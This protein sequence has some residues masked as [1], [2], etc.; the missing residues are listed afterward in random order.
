MDQAAR[1]VAAMREYLSEAPAGAADLPRQE[2]VDAAYE[3]LRRQFDAAWGGFGGAPKFPSPANLFLL[4]ELAD[5]PQADEMLDA[6]LDQMA[7]GGIYDQLGGG[8]HRYA[9]DREWKIP[10]FE[11]MLYDNGLLLEAYAQAHLRRPTPQRERILRQTTAFLA[12]EMT[13][14]EGGFWSAIDAE[15]EGH[16]G[17]FYVWT[18]DEL[19]GLLG[20]EDAAFLAPLF[21]F[22]GPPFFEG[23]HYVLHLPRPLEEQAALRQSSV[24]EIWSEVEPLRRKLFDARG[25]RERPRTDDKILAD[26]NG[27]A[28]A[29]L[30]WAGRALADEGVLEQARRAA[31]FVL[32]HHW[33]HSGAA[34]ALRHSWREGEAA[35]DGFLADYAYMVRGLLALH[36]ATGAE[37]W[38]AAARELTVE[39]VE[40][41]ETPEGG[42]FAAAAAPD[43]LLQSRDAYDD[44]LPNANGVA[45][46]N[47]LDLHAATGEERWRETAVRALVA[48][49]PA[50]ERQP[51][52]ARTL[53]LAG[54]RLRGRPG[55][56]PPSRKGPA[57]GVTSPET[58]VRHR[59]RVDEGEGWRPFV[60]ELE[61]EEGWH[62]HANPASE[63]PL[64][65]TRLEAVEG[66]LRN[67]TYPE[68]EPLEVGS[69]DAPLSVYQGVVCITGELRLEGERALCLTYQA[70]D[71]RRC[72]EVAERRIVVE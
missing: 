15:T 42:F 3:G 50:A 63:E 62:L 47:L 37:E 12:S 41:L 18:A 70:C 66:E 22:E 17:A 56:A 11:K 45:V 34:P 35:I 6:T 48:L 9:T 29:G 36:E 68:G 55:E 60:L 5:R 33:L 51:M 23:S 67:V 69:S 28:I 10:H 25:R 2:L 43:L 27:L 38:L 49:A 32:E 39:Q 30:A 65:P 4:L 7:R 19:R 59:L 61:I 72:L 52:A 53:V 16:E 1:I 71:E 13:S 21:G 26:W 31:R 8:F 46:L 24:E 14:P 64:I 54:H 58:L 57:A 40:L 20:E 44:A